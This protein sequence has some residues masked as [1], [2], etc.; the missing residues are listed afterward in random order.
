MTK[1]KIEMPSERAPDWFRWLG[2]A[3]CVWMAFGIFQFAGFLMFDPLSGNALE[4]EFVRSIPQWII[5]PFAILVFAGLAGAV[6]WVRRKALA[7]PML[8]LSALA[9]SVMH[10]GYAA[11]KA[12]REIM[13][14]GMWVMPVLITAI[15]WALWWVARRGAS[16]GWLA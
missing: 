10:G 4:Q 3:A 14:P 1:M 11:T 7:A 12:L 8:L 9:A 5:A 2:W 15:G 16:R 13:T 6:F